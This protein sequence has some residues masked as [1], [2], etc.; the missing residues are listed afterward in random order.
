MESL[1]R[2]S[3]CEKGPSGVPLAW[4]IR[5]FPPATTA[6]AHSRS[7]LTRVRKKLVQEPEKLAYIAIWL[8][9]QTWKK[10]PPSVKEERTIDLVRVYTIRSCLDRIDLTFLSILN[11][12]VMNRDWDHQ[13]CFVLSSLLINKFY[14]KIVQWHAFLFHKDH[15]G[16]AENPKKWIFLCSIETIFL[17]EFYKKGDDKTCE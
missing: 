15:R 13:L 6:T 4:K 10:I 1:S 3:R 5:F 16:F 14:E 17:E 11:R 12:R 9:R 2:F 8:D 7:R